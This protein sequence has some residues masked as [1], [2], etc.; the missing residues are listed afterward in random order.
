MF[1]LSQLSIKTRIETPARQ[2]DAGY[3]GEGL[4]QLS[5]KTRIETNT[6]HTQQNIPVCL[7]QLSIKTRIETRLC[8]LC[9]YPPGL[10]FESAIH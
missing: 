10:P 1:R 6:G 5:I 2:A 9:L 8:A 3:S 7:S 4:S